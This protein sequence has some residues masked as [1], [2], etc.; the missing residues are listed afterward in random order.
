[1]SNNFRRLAGLFV[2]LLL[3]AVPARA[4]SP[5]P[6]AMDAA[7]QLVET[8]NV[9]EHFKNLMPIIIKT[10]KPAIVQGRANVDR[11]FDAIVPAMMEVFQARLGELSDAYVII[12]ASNF[13]PDELRAIT[14]FYKTPAGQK[15]LQK[16][17]G[18]AAQTMTAGQKFGQSM[19]G[20]IQRRV[21]EELRKKGHTL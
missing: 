10:M 20:E 15:I 18:I 3:M 9:S 19:A 21:L 8:M 1:M 4:Q 7:K 16:T 13:S 11:D 14:A 5:S 6:E 12:Y 2:V 17:P